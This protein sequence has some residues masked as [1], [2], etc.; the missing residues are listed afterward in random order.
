[1]DYCGDYLVCRTCLILLA[2][3]ANVD[4][5]ASVSEGHLKSVPVGYGRID[6]NAAAHL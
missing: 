6:I 2:M 4:L 1:M 5:A 3:F